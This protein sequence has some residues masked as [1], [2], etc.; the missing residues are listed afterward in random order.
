MPEHSLPAVGT[1]SGRV[2]AL[3]DAREDFYADA[4]IQIDTDGKSVEDIA[5]EILYSLNR[6]SA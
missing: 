3:M 5:M 4:D 6:L 1:A 2:K